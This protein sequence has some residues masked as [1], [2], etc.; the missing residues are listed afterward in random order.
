MSCTDHIAC[1]IFLILQ[2]MPQ[3]SIINLKPFEK[4]SIIKVLQYNFGNRSLTFDISAGIHGQ[5]SSFQCKR[6]PEDVVMLFRNDL[7]SEDAACFCLFTYYIQ[8]KTVSCHP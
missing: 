4:C 1:I 5:D 8:Q 3:P 6:Y 2:K 7:A